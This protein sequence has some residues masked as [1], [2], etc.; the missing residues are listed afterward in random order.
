MDTGTGLSAASEAEAKE[1]ALKEHRQ[2]ISRAHRE[3]A[4][5]ATEAQRQRQR[6]A[7]NAGMTVEEYMIASN[8]QVSRNLY[9]SEAEKSALAARLTR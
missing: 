5:A 9:A 6:A 7:M 8:M 2:R 1:L 4:N 3:A